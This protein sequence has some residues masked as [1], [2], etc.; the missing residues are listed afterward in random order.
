L[1][2]SFLSALVNWPANCQ[3]CSGAYSIR[4]GWIRDC[5]SIRI[6][7]RSSG[8]RDSART[9]KP[10]I[11]ISVSPES[12][13]FKWHY[14]PVLNSSRLNPSSHRMLSRPDKYSMLQVLRVVVTVT[15]NFLD[16]VGAVAFWG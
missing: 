15:V 2:T 11:S 6:F 13:S 5:Y 16:V 9:S 3:N 8:Y 12:P 14:S 1:A 7:P 10:S 4:F